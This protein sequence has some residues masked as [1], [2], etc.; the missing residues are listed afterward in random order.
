MRILNLGCGTKTSDSADVVNIDWSTYLRI[1]VNPIARA[2]APLV[3]D[4][5]QLLRLRALP[6]NIMVHNLAKGIPFADTTVDVVYHSHVLEHFDV[7]PA[8]QFLKE[9]LRVLKP[10]GV[11]R[12]AVPDFEMM[13]R[14]YMRH[15]EI[16]E[17]DTEAMFDHDKY[18]AP[19]IEQCVRRESF[20]T[21]HQ[22]GIRRVLENAILGDA[23]KRGETH[24][25]MYDRFNLQAALRKAGFSDTQ[26]TTYD[27]SWIKDWVSY[28]LDANAD[29]SQY[30]TDSL[31]VEARKPT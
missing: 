31:Y 19:M 24:Q 16:C 5:N 7:S 3:L 11:L 22:T 13:V 8:R 25:W 12:V 21:S 9:A 27:N 1:S 23:R 17:I 20:S 18:I 4:K 2:I 30:K 10:G 28:G 14:A 29:G 6:S 15:L 26:V